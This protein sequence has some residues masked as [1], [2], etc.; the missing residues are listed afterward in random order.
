MSEGIFC[1][2]EVF[3][4]KWFFWDLWRRTAV[5]I[6][7]HNSLSVYGGGVMCAASPSTATG[8]FNPRTQS[9]ELSP[10]DFPRNMALVPPPPSAWHDP[11]LNAHLSVSAHSVGSGGTTPSSI[12]KD[13]HLTNLSAS[14]T[15]HSTVSNGASSANSANGT[16]SANTSG[17]SSDG[18]SYKPLLDSKNCIPTASTT[19]SSQANS[20][21]SSS[22]GGGSSGNIKNE[23]IECIV[24]GDKSS[25]KHYGQFTCEGKFF[26]WDFYG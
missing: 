5:K 23:N 26:Y 8:F 21:Q 12:G 4:V 10:L 17:S 14:N 16:N 20:S 9:S 1:G 22:N 6:I 2:S 25:G 7:T 13:D 19:P 15:H 3:E 24:C 18:L 11:N